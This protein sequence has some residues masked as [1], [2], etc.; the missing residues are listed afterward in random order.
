MI[1]PEIAHRGDDGRFSRAIAVHQPHGFTRESLPDPNALKQCFLATDD[2]QT[3]GRGQ[4]HAFLIQ[5]VGEFVPVGRRQIQDS[6][7]P[8]VALI[9]KV[10][11]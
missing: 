7:S 6:H 1:L 8:C 5:R 2:H 9:Q 3:N 11:R 4:R 10:A